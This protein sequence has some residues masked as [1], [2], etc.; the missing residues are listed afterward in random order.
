MKNI[1]KKL[2]L[3]YFIV[4]NSVLILGTNY[5]FGDIKFDNVYSLSNNHILLEKDKKDN[6]IE[7]LQFLQGYDDIVAIAETNNESLI[8]IYDPSMEYYVAAT[9][10]INPNDFRYFD[11]ED[12]KEK[13]KVGIVITSID[14]I[15]KGGISEIDDELIRKYY[16]LDIIN[17]FDTSSKIV[18]K[19]LRIVENLFALD[20][21]VINK[22]YIDSDNLK[23]LKTVKESMKDLGYI[24]I[25][26]NNSSIV[27]SFIKSFLDSTSHSRTVIMTLLAVFIAEVYVLNL[28]VSEMKKR[29]S[30]KFSSFILLSLLCIFV[31]LILTGL[32]LHLIGK[33]SL[34]V[35]NFIEIQVFLTLFAAGVYKIS[36]DKPENLVRKHE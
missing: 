16:N 32:Y 23:E 26:P 13:N 6:S 21:N 10:F 22:I 1:Y 18:Y 29:Y 28:Y 36:S 30:V 31:S 33:L 17:Y 35:V 24:E 9:K 11:T 15:K 8:G 5:L 12:Y 14:K 25:K 3:L 19:N 7:E 2:I 34:G 27:S 20:S 4:I